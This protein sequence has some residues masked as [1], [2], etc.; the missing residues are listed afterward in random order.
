MADNTFLICTCIAMAFV[1]TFVAA[2]MVT[3][4]GLK[5]SGLQMQK[6]KKS[7]R[8]T[9]D[10]LNSSVNTMGLEMTNLN[11]S[12]GLTKEEVNKNA[13]DAKTLAEFVQEKVQEFGNK[14]D[15]LLKDYVAPY[16][17]FEAHMSSSDSSPTPT[18]STTMKYSD[19]K[20]NL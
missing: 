19:V 16:S 14:T 20:I 10:A 18:L 6:W 13:N 12:V 11:L 7:T 8:A 4:E 2:D 1:A 17:A 5:S 15:K 9:I 3:Y